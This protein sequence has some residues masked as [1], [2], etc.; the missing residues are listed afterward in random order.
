MS[1]FII[2]KE[3]KNRKKKMGRE[4]GRKGGELPRRHE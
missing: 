3:R 2:W 1:K 4:E